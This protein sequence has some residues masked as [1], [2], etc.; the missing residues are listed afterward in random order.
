ML[1]D[2]RGLSAAAAYLKNSAVGIDKICQVVTAGEHI[3]HG[4]FGDVEPGQI[5]ITEIAAVGEHLIHIR[6]HGGIET[7]QIQT[8]QTAAA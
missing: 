7:G 6:Y 2:D 3:E 5:Q 8:G 4:R 1:D